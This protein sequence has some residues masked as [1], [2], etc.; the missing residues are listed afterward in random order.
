MTRNLSAAVLK[1]ACADW[2]FAIFASAHLEGVAFFA[3]EFFGVVLGK[4]MISVLGLAV[5]AISFVW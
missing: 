4:S 2:L 5:A 1:Q 3:E